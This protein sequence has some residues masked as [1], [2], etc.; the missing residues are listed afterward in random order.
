MGS[1]APNPNLRVVGIRGLDQGCDVGT[2]NVGPFDRVVRFIGPIHILARCV[3]TNEPFSRDRVDRLD[4]GAICVP[5]V[6]GAR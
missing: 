3:Q 2:I 5:S 1:I 4:A 6:N